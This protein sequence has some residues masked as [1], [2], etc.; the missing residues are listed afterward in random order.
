MAAKSSKVFKCT[1]ELDITTLVNKLKKAKDSTIVDNPETGDSVTLRTTITEIE[2]SSQRKVVRGKMV[3]ETPVEFKDDRDG[4]I[5]FVVQKKET[6]FSFLF[7]SLFFV[8]FTTKEE[9]GTVA[10]KI[11]RMIQTK[12]DSILSCQISTQG[13]KQF[14]ASHRHIMTN[15][16]WKGLTIPNLSGAQLIGRDVEN[17]AD[18][19]RY[20]GRGEPKSVR[21]R[22]TENNWALLINEQAVVTFYNNPAVEEMEEFLRREIFPICN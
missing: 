10:Y 2:A 16:Y 21:L 22:L 18:Y 8:P 11:G 6:E 9:A 19:K 20:D 5:K 17:T 15:I 7:G 12:D 14:L 1:P 13:I 4:K 3:A